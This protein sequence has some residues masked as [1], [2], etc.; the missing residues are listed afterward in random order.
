MDESQPMRACLTRNS[1]SNSVALV[2]LDT[3]AV[4]DDAEAICLLRQIFPELSTVE[5]KE[6]HRERV[7]EKQRT[8][9]PTTQ[10]GSNERKRAYLLPISKL[11]RRIMDEL[12][13]EE[14]VAEIYWRKHIT[15]PHDFLRLPPSMAIRKLDED[16]GQWHYQLVDD[17]EKRAM[18]QHMLFRD[19]A[20]EGPINL[21]HY[22]TRAIFRDP[23]IGL[24]LTLCELNGSIWV[25]SLTSRN[26]RVRTLSLDAIEKVK[27]PAILAQISPGDALIGINGT[28]LFE[29]VLPDETLL[30]HAVRA[31]KESDDPVVLH[32]FRKELIPQGVKSPVDVQDTHAPRLKFTIS[33]AS[34]Q[35][36]TPPSDTTFNSTPLNWISKR[37]LVHPF[38]ALLRVKGILN[39]YEAERS[40]TNMLYQYTERALQWESTPSFSFP[41][42]N[43]RK[44]LCVHIVNSFLDGNETAY[45]IW[46]YDIE[47]GV[48][49][50]A[51]IRYLRDFCDLKALV[52]DLHGC[53][54]EL[55][56]PRQAYSLFGSPLRKET[57]TTGQSKCRQLEHFLHFLCSM[58]Y[59]EHLNP[60]VV[61]ALVY[62][63]SFLGCE[64]TLANPAMHSK[65]MLDSSVVLRSLK[66]SI[67]QFTYRLMLLEGVQKVIKAFIENTRAK[68]PRLEEL[69]FLES[70]GRS[71]L[72]NRAMES[73][74]EARTFLDQLQNMIIEGCMNDF[75]SI[76]EWDEYRV[77]NESFAGPNGVVLWETL[78]REAVREQ[79]EIEVYVPLRGVMSRWL[80]NGWRHED[81]EI[82]FKISELRK[83]PQV[84]FRIAEG[85]LSPT[86][87][88]TVCSILK[89]G[90]GQSTLPC[91][92]LR[93]IVEAAREISRLVSSEHGATHLGQEGL[94]TSRSP[95]LGA[96]NFL[97]I[98]IYCMVKADLDRPCALGVLLKTLCDPI[99]KI[100]EIGYYLACYE[101]AMSYIQELDLS[102]TDD[103]EIFLPLL[104]VPLDDSC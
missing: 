51:P 52:T 96:D 103:Q 8:T 23:D 58:I 95:N 60:N 61:E 36:S 89:E 79:I 94:A 35:T 74:D 4:E 12:S 48:E 93:A 49:W 34:S 47:T 87:W 92:K 98:F 66:R 59:K 33:D 32:L 10:R 15:L 85:M 18:Q 40:N 30:Q 88:S 25:H 1:S 26:C 84:R 99:N 80:V 39:S 27:G 16:S 65:D 56:F 43:V 73:L 57:I 67:Q 5:L 63:Q 24:G 21:Q 75:Q 54:A 2:E 68:G 69:E 71:V 20:K 7:G 78:V 37:P 38:V 72:K 64:M 70:Q 14:R 6:L 22:Y 102:V 91:V 77:L 28:A 90:V 83:R 42:A 44:A 31:I 50:Y 46:V 101:A 41:L 3:C 9:S 62:V 97:P 53:I 17:L 82:Q 86:G 45:T 55:P 104:P 100:G 11:G 19:L 81:I 13:A 29:G 76:G